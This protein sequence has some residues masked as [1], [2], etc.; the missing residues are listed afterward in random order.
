LVTDEIGAS[1]AAQG[2]VELRGF[3]TFAVKRQ[4][5]RMGRNPRTGAPVKVPPKYVPQ[6]RVGKE[7]RTR[8]NSPQ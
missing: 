2:R 7:L 1:L 5:S 6:F 4:R 3:G 8:L